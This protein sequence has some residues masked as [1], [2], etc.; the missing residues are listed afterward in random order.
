MDLQPFTELGIDKAKAKFALVEFGGN[1]EAALDWCYEEVRFLFLDLGSPAPPCPF[2]FCSCS[3]PTDPRP[4]K[5]KKMTGQKL[6]PPIPAR[7]EDCSSSSSISLASSYLPL[8][9]DDRARVFSSGW[10][11]LLLLSASASPNCRPWRFRQHRAETRSGYR[12]RSRGHSR[13]GFDKRGSP[14]RSQS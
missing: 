11:L 10:S 14:T 1:V 8:P 7:N 5:I 12:E 2:G 6:D 13:R 3:I 9:L 4:K